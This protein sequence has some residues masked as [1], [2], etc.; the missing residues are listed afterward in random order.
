M[1]KNE[2]IGVK[3]YK[4]LFPD[5]KGVDKTKLKLT[6]E[7]TY[8]I[9]KPNDG[10]E[11]IK[12]INKYIKEKLDKLVITDATANVGGDTINFSKYFKKVNAVELDKVNCKFLKNN[13]NVYN[14]KNVNIICNDYIK[15]SNEL[16]QDIIY[17]DPPWGGVKYYKF[18]KKYSKSE[19]INLYL[20]KYNIIDVL[21]KLRK[22]ASYFIL[23]LPF[24]YDYLKFFRNFGNCKIKKLYQ[25]GH[26][27]L[28]IFIKI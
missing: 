7:S 11:L 2:D 18:H 21:K 8:S 12:I 27:I 13:I 24:N 14:R 22:K 20:G 23:K 26:R 6:F 15:V 4:H 28:F 1:K 17:I 3:Y 9:T 19:K 16:I 5:E 10:I 25:L